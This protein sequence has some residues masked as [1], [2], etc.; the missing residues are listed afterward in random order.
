[1]KDADA[2]LRLRDRPKHMKASGSSLS[3]SGDVAVAV[4][5]VPP[6]AS[7]AH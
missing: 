7:T 2:L 5:E 6:V 1:M 3:G 4:V